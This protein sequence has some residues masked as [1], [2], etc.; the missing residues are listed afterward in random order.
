[1]LVYRLRGG[2]IC[3]STR[4]VGPYTAD[5]AR[6]IRHSISTMRTTLPVS[7]T[8][9][10]GRAR[11]ATPARPMRTIRTVPY[12]SPSKDT[13]RVTSSSSSAAA[14]SA[15]RTSCSLRPVSVTL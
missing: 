6:R 2:N 1:M 8:R 11:R 9:N 15:L 4:A 5:I 7:R 3:D 10:C 14:V 13:P 12:R